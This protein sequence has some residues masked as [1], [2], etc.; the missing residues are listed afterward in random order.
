M[1]G[2]SKWS[3]IKRQ[4]GVSD[5]KRGAAF[6]KLANAITIAVRE[7]G[8]IGD[9]E[10]NFKL[11]LTIEKAR[12]M[13]MPKE[14]IQRAI[15]RGQ[16]KG[17]NEVLEEAVYEGFGPGGTAI[18]VEATTDKKLRTTSEI[19]NLFE[20]NGATLGT[21][22]SV[23]YQFQTKGLITVVKN[24]ASFDDIFEAAVEAGADDIEDAGEEVNIYTDPSL[25]HKI[26]EMLQEKFS[27]TSAELV[28]KPVVTVSVTDKSVAEKLLSF[29]EKVE[30]HDDVQKVYSN[31]DIPD[32]LITL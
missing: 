6:T 9:P 11:R 25:V 10:G 8:G 22:G 17:G 28:R 2:H 23:S 19:K 3:Q 4:K 15:E 1:S 21:P 24:Q 32:D 5:V 29:M 31:F 12:A 27:V 7:G 18:I 30:G 26:K 16:G 13:N 20:K 14:N